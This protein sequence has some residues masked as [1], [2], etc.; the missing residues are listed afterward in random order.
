MFQRNFKKI[1]INSFSNDNDI[2]NPNFPRF[3]FTTQR[4]D[5]LDFRKLKTVGKY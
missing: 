3:Y 5:L 4:N 1:N 2:E